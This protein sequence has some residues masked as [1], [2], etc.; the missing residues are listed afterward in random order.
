MNK[1]ILPKKKA[2]TI[3]LV[4]ALGYYISNLLRAITATISPNLISEFNLSAGDL[5]LLGGGYFL[6]FASVQ[7]PLGYLLDNKG[8]KKIVSYFLLI[9]IAG[10]ISFSLSQNFT[11]LLIS[12]ILIG[13]GVG[14]CLMGPLTAYRVWFQD[15]TQQRANS[16]MLMTGAIGMLSSSLPIQF[17]LPIIGWRSIFG[18]L[19]ILTLLSIILIVIFIP[20]WNKE[21]IKN[22]HD[23]KGSLKEVW[24]NKFFKS[25]VPMG[26]FNYGGLFA[27]QTLW[28][29]PWMVKVSGYTPEESANG[30]FIIYLSLLFSFLTWGY[31]VPKFSKNVSDAI[32]LLKFGAPINLVV[33]AFI[34]Y[35]GPK[36]GAFHWA[37]FAVS[38][39]FLS[40]SQPAVGM[41]FS[42]SNAGKA[43]TSFNLLLFIG[44]FAL[45]WIIGVI[46]DLT[47]NLGF[48]EISGFR[49]AMVFF[50]LTSLFSYLFFLTKNY[51][52]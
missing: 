34:I 22:T 35:L 43:L 42:L 45:Q 3:F 19:A 32:R 47:M 41:A 46:I 30:L 27:I 11:S 15:E 44:A 5:G 2:I 49:F 33:L 17:F 7:I 26:F 48:S 13:V 36:A 39:V 6:G 31:F 18:I 37:L 23:E 12:R 10:I 9:A 20:N 1:V 52:N 8:P 21:N 24:Q 40:L 25:L 16:W 28:A 38:S 29:G 51:K 4:F 50:L 14:A